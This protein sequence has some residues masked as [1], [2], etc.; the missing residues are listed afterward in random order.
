MS[1]SP[2]HD[3]FCPPV[4]KFEA[5]APRALTSLDARTWLSASSGL[6]SAEL[7]RALWHGGLFVH[8]HR[9]DEAPALEAG[10]PVRLYSFTRDP[11]RVEV[12]G[13]HILH[14]NDHWVAVN[15]PAWLPVQGTRASRR[16]SLETQLRELTGCDWLSPVHRLD[17]QTSGVNLFAKTPEAFEC[18]AKQFRN[19]TARKRYVARVTALPGGER[20]SVRAHQRRAHHP[21]HAFFRCVSE[22]G[23]ATQEGRT[24]FRVRDRSAHL[25]EAFPSTGRTHQIRLHLAFASGPI[26]GD[27]LYGEPWRPGIPHRLL[28]HAE[29]LTL[30]DPVGRSVEYLAP[31]P[32]E[33]L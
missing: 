18:A 30:F 3:R 13:E 5:V 17:R 24:E 7:D 21:S 12:G 20:W 16:I 27:A 2:T 26:L 19:R 1:E 32:S 31:L 9:C 11:E 14:E 28:L 23:P 6:S 22:A 4:R 8:A 29:C 25:V 15:K 10:A 33:F